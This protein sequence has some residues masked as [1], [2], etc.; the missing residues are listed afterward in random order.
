[1]RRA[2]L[3]VPVLLTAFAP[4]AGACTVDNCVEVRTATA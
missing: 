1:M 3:A 4:A 2:V